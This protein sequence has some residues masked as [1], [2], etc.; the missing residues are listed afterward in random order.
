M[1]LEEQIFKGVF[2]RDFGFGFYANRAGRVFWQWVSDCDISEFILECAF[3]IRG[4]DKRIVFRLERRDI[5]GHVV[6]DWQGNW[7]AYE[8]FV[9]SGFEVYNDADVGHSAF[10]FFVGDGI[11]RFIRKVKVR[12]CQRCTSIW[13]G[14]LSLGLPFTG[15]C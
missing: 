5:L 2:K 8:W 9:C 15:S 4:V 14:S 6:A 12:I 13:G 10:D 1:F 3:D 11:Y 7:G